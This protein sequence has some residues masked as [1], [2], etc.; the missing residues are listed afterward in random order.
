[1]K[2]CC[3][4]P[5]A[6]RG[7]RLNYDRPKVFVPILENKMIIDFLYALVSPHC[8]GINLVLS[9]DGKK[10]TDLIPVDKRIEVSIQENPIGM[11]DAIFKGYDF[12][13]DYDYVYIIWGDQ[14]NV[15]QNT[16]ELMTNYARRKQAVIPLTPQKD[17]YVEYVFDQKNCLSNIKQSREGDN[18]KKNGL[19]DIGLFGLPVNGLQNFWE[20]YL[21][22]PSV[23]KE[24]NEIN[25]LPFLTFLETNNL[26]HFENFIVPDVNESKGVNTPEDLLFFQKHFS[27][28]KAS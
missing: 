10:Y 16:M 2:I 8:D 4:I 19:S 7:T 11:G 1:M 13:S 28:L 9:P 17:P 23:G 6:G 24:T 20:S 26:I 25:F 15:S 5:A 12:W 22:K 18:C 14:V 27:E 21:E 3:I